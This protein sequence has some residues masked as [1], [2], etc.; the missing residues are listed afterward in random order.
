LE[1]RE[2]EVAIQHLFLILLGEECSVRIRNVS[3]I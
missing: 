3:A 2:R 1:E